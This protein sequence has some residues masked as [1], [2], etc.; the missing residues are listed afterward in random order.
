MAAVP[1]DLRPEL[2]G[3][4]T[5]RALVSWKFLSTE[6]KRQAVQ[7]ALAAG[8]GLNDI[9]S[10]ANVP[11]YQVERMIPRAHSAA[12]E[13]RERLAT[14]RFVSHSHRR[15]LVVVGH[16]AGF[17]VDEMA[18]LAKVPRSDV[19]DVAYSAPPVLDRPAKSAADPE[20]AACATAPAVPIQASTSAAPDKGARAEKRQRRSTGAPVAYQRSL[21]EGR[22]P[23]DMF[24]VGP[25]RYVNRKS[26]EELGL[27]PRSAGEP[28]P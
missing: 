2:E 18:L 21:A 15:D 1:L 24:E 23:E 14:W 20:P 17:S 4:M 13:A 11:R 16:A 19:E 22:P 7:A 25:H 12:D 9:A 26:V 28:R 6:G 3:R 27:T 8:W 10:A 5:M